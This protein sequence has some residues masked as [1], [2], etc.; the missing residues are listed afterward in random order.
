M[1]QSEFN[2]NR[3]TR[4]ARIEI[5]IH[6]IFNVTVSERTYCSFVATKNMHKQK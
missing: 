1:I 2:R 4:F 3:N 6:F 5:V